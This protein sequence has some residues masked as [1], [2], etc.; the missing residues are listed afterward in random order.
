MRLEIFFSVLFSK[1]PIRDG[2]ALV[3][4]KICSGILFLQSWQQSIF[5]FLIFFFTWCKKK[6]FIVNDLYYTEIPTLRKTS[7]LH[8]SNVRKD[9]NGCT[10]AHKIVITTIAVVTFTLGG[11]VLL[12]SVVK[13]GSTKQERQLKF[14]IT[15]Q[16]LV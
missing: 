7:S 12:T 6:T 3:A 11:H 8:A 15:L 1:K 16:R 4:S 2:M 9:K 13:L 5:H 10:V 14:T